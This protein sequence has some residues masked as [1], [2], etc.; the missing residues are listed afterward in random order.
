MMR[1]IYRFIRKCKLQDFMNTTKSLVFDHFWGCQ[2]EA[3]PLRREPKY[4][5]HGK[6]QTHLS[7]SI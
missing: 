5:S 4:L 1:E 3:F 6:G 2:A 7:E